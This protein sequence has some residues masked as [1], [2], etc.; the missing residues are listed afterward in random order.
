VEGEDGTA[1]VG[2]EKDPATVTKN[3]HKITDMFYFPAADAGPLF[4]RKT[5]NLLSVVLHSPGVSSPGV[6]P[7]SIEGHGDIA[8]EQAAGLGDP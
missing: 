3:C 6:R 7:I 1:K 5:Q 8:E 2:V 4:R